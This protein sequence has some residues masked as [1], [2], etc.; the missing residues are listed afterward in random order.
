MKEAW[1]KRTKDSF[2]RSAAAQLAYENNYLPEALRLNEELRSRLTVSG[3][4]PPEE[5]NSVKHG[6]VRVTMKIVEF[7][8]HLENMARKL[9][10]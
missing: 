1:E 7:A 2:Q 10:D 4:L 8:D 9:P 3:I 6:F 5:L